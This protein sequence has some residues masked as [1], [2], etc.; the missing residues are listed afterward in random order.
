M[1]VLYLWPGTYWLQRIQL[2]QLTNE[3]LPALRDSFAASQP[4]R[5]QLGH[6]IRRLKL[7]D[8][9][10]AHPKEN[11]Q[12]RKARLKK[13]AV[14]TERLMRLEEVTG[15]IRALEYVHSQ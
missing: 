15:L 1:Q 13:L 6:D 2:F 9:L 5:E 12:E 7:P 14:A 4:E 8:D 11:T 10:L 3:H